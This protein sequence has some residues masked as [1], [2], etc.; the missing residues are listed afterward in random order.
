[1]NHYPIFLVWKEV[2]CFLR[3]G[4]EGAAAGRGKYAGGLCAGVAVVVRWLR[5]S[6]CPA[7]DYDD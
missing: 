7:A 1:M 3:R 2:Y 5:G 4:A 6:A